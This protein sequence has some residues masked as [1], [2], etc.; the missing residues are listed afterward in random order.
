MGLD[1]WEE[2]NL[3]GQSSVFMAPPGVL[4][5]IKS[6]MIH[7]NIPFEIINEN[8]QRKLDV[9]WEELDQTV[10]LKSAAGDK[11]FNYDDWNTYED[12][13]EELDQLAADCN[14]T[15]LLCSVFSIGDSYEGRPIKMIKISGGEGEE[16]AYWI[17]SAIHAREWLAPATVMKVANHL[18][19][20]YGINSDATNMVDKYD[21]YILPV[22][23]P[24]GFV[25]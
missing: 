3:V 24:D 19:R 14:V 10:S 8:V 15:G 9:M 17:D 25:Y 7:R 5:E 16:K 21:W 6:I 23:N 12:M 4:A 20:N 18:I 13:M 11:T 2:P 22:M 1:F